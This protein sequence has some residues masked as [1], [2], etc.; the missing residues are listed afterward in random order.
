MITDF[1]QEAVEVR[2]LMEK[3]IPALARTKVAL[4]AAFEQDQACG[5][6]R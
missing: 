1:A 4:M 3:H 2:P 5:A 6:W